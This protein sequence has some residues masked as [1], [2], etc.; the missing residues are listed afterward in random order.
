[1]IA[2]PLEVSPGQVPAGYASWR[3]LWSVAASFT[4]HE[5]KS[6]APPELL[7]RAGDEGVLL[8]QEVYQNRWPASAFLPGHSQKGRE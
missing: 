6:S 1:M 2:G 7:C 4:C 3:M 8:E 5:C